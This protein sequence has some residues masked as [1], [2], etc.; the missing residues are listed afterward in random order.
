MKR[1]LV[2]A[3]GAI[4]LSGA[5]VCVSPAEAQNHTPQPAPLVMNWKTVTWDPPA[6]DRP[7]FPTGL[8]NAQ[9]TIDPGTGGPTYLARFPAGS[10]FEMHWHTYT[11]T[12]VVMEG[13]VDIVLDG[14]RHTASAG[15]Y[16]II[17]GKAHHTWIVPEDGDV[18]LLA[19][20]DGPA[21]F[22][23]VGP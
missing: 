21:D 6:P 22:H 8:Q 14:T 11:E 2:T 19:R 20:R 1:T 10:R 23:F 3:M 15:S 18:V 16:I 12:A 4:V 9:I 13:T 17:P 5:L 7:R